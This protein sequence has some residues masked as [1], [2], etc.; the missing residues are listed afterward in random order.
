MKKLKE[1]IGVPRNTTGFSCELLCLIETP[2]QL[3]EL[4]L[5]WHNLYLLAF[6]NVHDRYLNKIIANRSNFFGTKHEINSEF[7]TSLNENDEIR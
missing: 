4:D 6:F 1:V 2:Q 5:Y 7:Q 3:F